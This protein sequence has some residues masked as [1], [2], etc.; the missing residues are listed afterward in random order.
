MCSSLSVAWRGSRIPCS[1]LSTAFELTFSNRA[2]NAWLALRAARSARISAGFS[3]F[4]RAG[5]SVLRRSRPVFVAFA[6]AVS[7]CWPCFFFPFFLSFLLTS[8]PLMPHCGSTTMWHKGVRREQER[9]KEGEEEARPAAGNGG[10]KS[11]EDRPRSAQDGAA[12]SPE[13]AEAGRYSRAAGRPQCQPGVAGAIAECQLERGGKLGAGNPRTAPGHAQAAA[14]REEEPQRAAG[15][16]SR[17]RGA[18]E[19]QPRIFTDRHG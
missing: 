9:Q 15:L 5:S 7:G 2:S 19:K 1:Q 10:G 16:A 14:H 8:H 3:G 4:G 18:R 6:A 17:C 13:A 11:D 12:C